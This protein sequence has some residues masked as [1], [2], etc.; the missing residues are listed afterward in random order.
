MTT[1]TGVT[2]CCVVGGGPA[3]A[4]LSLLLARAGVPVTLLERHSDFD[5]DFRGDTLH[6]SVMEIL[7]QLGLADRLLELPHAKIRSAS[8]HTADGVLRLADFGRLR[9]RFPYI[10]M[11]PQVH[12][13]EFITREASRYP[14]FR[15]VMG[16]RVEA[17][18][19]D[20]GAVR[21]V[22]YRGADGQHELEA[23]LVVGADGRFSAVRRLAGAE[24]STTSPP[25]DV[26]WFRLPRSAG[27]AQET[28][29]GFLRSGS[30]AVLLDRGGEWQVALV[31]PKGSFQELRDRGIHALRE[32]IAR[33]APPLAD[34]VDRLR[35]WSQVSLLSVASD[36]LRRWYRP[37][38]LMIGDAAHVMSPVAGVGINY[39]VQDAV[40]AANLLAGPLLERRL[41]VRHL[42]A[43]QRR[44]DWPTRL[45]Q[46]FQAA[47]LGGV[48]AP[49]LRSAGP[50]TLPLPVRLARRIPGLRDLPARLIA[51]GV[52]PARVR[53]PDPAAALP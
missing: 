1:E 50:V 21:G 37:G 22:R 3:G 33:T 31:I 51:F 9:T 6:P 39:A 10:T 20:G 19:E 35:D 30:A 18:L 17:L 36:R 16:A 43:V 12:F 34:R 29:T 5:R 52:R 11:L 14:A 15:L 53:L 48:V 26:L 13:L 28:G 38:L 49:A 8:I 44:R 45:I 42:A 41:R 24:A 46:A 25:V 40:E 32:R 4:V 47:A 23:D 2:T 7:D 27:D